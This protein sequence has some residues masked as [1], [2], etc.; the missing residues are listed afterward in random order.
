MKNAEPVGCRDESTK[1]ILNEFGIKAINNECITLLLDKRSKKEE[2]NAKKIILVDVD[3]FIPLPKKDKSDF[4][5]L[6]HLMLAIDL[7]C[8]ISHDLVRQW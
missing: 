5:Y 2:L 3:E 4:I 8:L 1:E 6:S 7:F